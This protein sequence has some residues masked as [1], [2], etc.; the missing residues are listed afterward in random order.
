[1][2][3]ETQTNENGNVDETTANYIAAIKELKEK[4][5]DRSEYE[6]VVADNKKL[7]DSVIN[8]STTEQTEEQPKESVEDLR[9][10]IFGGELN[11]LDY[12]V[13]ILELRKRLIESGQADPFLP[14]GHQIAPTDE[15]VACANKVAQVLQE[16]IDYAEGDAQVFTNELQ[17]RTI[18][19]R[20]R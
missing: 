6:K 5:V 14:V 11:N 20:I 8:G 2:I 1:M 12:T 16:C 17:R 13:K 7:L 18:D 15:D 9:K 10:S 4:T 19:V 3:D